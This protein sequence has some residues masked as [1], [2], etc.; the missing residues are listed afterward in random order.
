MLRR[1][2][3]DCALR[4]PPAAGSGPLM[5]GAGSGAALPA[6][7]SHPFTWGGRLR[8]V[9]QDFVFL[10]SGHRCV[11]ALSTAVATPATRLAFRPCD[12]STPLIWTPR[13]SAN[14]CLISSFCSAR[15][16]A[17]CRRLVAGW[18]HLLCSRHPTCSRWTRRGLQQQPRHSRWAIAVVA[19]SSQPGR[20]WQRIC[21]R[22]AALVWNTESTLW[23]SFFD[24][25]DFNKRL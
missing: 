14:A 18:V 5:L 12:C 16:S 1:L 10:G 23:V 17:S 15:W 9:P 13:K 11:A 19:R 20:Q 7:V 25:F 6:G 22:I 3:E 4:R 8:R 21:A 24:E 2:F